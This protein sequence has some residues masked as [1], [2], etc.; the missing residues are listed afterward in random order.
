MPSG[1]PVVT[2]EVGGIVAVVDA[3]A[4]QFVARELSAIFEPCV[5]KKGFQCVPYGHIGVEVDAGSRSQAAA[6]GGL[7]EAGICRNSA[8]MV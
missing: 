1:L 8:G 7:A 3:A 6:E 2:Y 4:G 5:E